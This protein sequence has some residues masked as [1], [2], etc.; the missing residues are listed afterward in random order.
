MESLSNRFFPLERVFAK[1]RKTSRQ[2]SR[3]LSHT[4]LF[5]FTT[6][7]QYEGLTFFGGGDNYDHTVSERAQPTVAHDRCGAHYT[8]AGR[9]SLLLDRSRF[10]C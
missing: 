6:V 5:E 2:L 7:V 8:C 4:F 10:F 1:G 3:G 9:Q